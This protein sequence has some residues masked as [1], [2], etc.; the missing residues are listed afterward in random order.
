MHKGNSAS[1]SGVGART[2][3]RFRCF[4]GIRRMF[5]E[6]MGRRAEIEAYVDSKTLFDVVEGTGERKKKDCRY[7]FALKE[8]Y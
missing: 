3:A 6:I 4:Y 7:I 2:S 1:L 5:Y 8:S